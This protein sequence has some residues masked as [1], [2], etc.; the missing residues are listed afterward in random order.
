MIQGLNQSDTENQYHFN[1]LE[2][3]HV[4]FNIKKV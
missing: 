2:K 1:S 4:T 3:P